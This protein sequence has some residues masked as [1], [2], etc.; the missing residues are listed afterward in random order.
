MQRKGSADGILLNLL[1]KDCMKW[2]S[3]KHI[4]E[5]LGRAYLDVRQQKFMQFWDI[6]LWLWEKWEVIYKEENIYQILQD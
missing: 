2:L 3:W 1:L 6:L 5:H 4:L